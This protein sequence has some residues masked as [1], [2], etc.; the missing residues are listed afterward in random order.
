MSCRVSACLFVL[1]CLHGDT[2]RKDDET[3]ET[4]T[5][6]SSKAQAFTSEALL[7]GGACELFALGGAWR[8]V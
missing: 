5:I 3:V 1:S 6:I 4:R 8:I 7:S 2:T